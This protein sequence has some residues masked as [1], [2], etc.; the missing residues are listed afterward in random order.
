MPGGAKIALLAK[1]AGPSVWGR[2]V[3]G[4]QERTTALQGNGWL[5]A[6]CLCPRD[7]TWKFWMCSLP[8]KEI[9]LLLEALL[10]WQL[11]FQLCT[12]AEAVEMLSGDVLWVES[13]AGSS[14][15]QGAQDGVVRKAGVIL[16][17]P[18]KAQSN[19]GE[20]MEL[21]TPLISVPSGQE[22]SYP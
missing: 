11:F 1:W 10:I 19:H 7:G 21:L 9:Q 4:Q 17:S 12:Q 5:S 16:A 14:H 20:E 13:R 18:E 22:N 2:G 8:D 15:S 3:T 6:Q